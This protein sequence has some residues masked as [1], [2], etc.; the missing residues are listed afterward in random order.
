MNITKQF[1]SKVLPCS[2][3]AKTGEEKLF[4]QN[5]NPVQG[6]SQEFLHGGRFEPWRLKL[7]TMSIIVVWIVYI[8]RLI[9]TFFEIS[10][11]DFILF[12]DREFTYLFMWFWIMIYLFRLNSWTFEVST[13]VS[14]ATSV[15]ICELLTSFFLKNASIVFHLLIN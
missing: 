7:T 11:L 6:R 10:S 15:L 8:F 1:T 5:Q 13:F 14:I 4:K 12:V 9:W 3:I 2:A